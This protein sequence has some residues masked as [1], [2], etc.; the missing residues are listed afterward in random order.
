MTKRKVKLSANEINR[1]IYCPYQWYYGKVYGQKA[2]KEKYQ[3]LD[4][5]KSDHEG[6]FKKGLQFHACYYRQYRLKRMLQ[7]LVII[8]II[9]IVVV[10]GVA[11][12][13]Q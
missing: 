8:A 4:R 12:W 10:G 5:K 7:I 13:W 1:Y 9:A 6:N 11:K 3:A 2:L